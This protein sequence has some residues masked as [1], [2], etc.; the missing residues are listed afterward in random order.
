MVAFFVLKRLILGV[1][2]ENYCITYVDFGNYKS[3]HVQQFRLINLL[4]Y[5][6]FRDTVHKKLCK[7]CDDC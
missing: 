6:Q 4:I 7:L 3:R 1:Q 2:G 5:L